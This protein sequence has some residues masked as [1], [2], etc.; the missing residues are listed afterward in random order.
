[1]NR[2]R[3]VDNKFQVIITP[4]IKISPDSSLI[5]GNFE[6]ENLRNFHVLQF[7]TLNDALCEAYNYPDIDWY[8]IVLNHKYIFKRLEDT[9]KQIISDNQLN[10]EF[11]SKLV[12]PLALKNIMFDRVLRGGERFNLRTGL[13]DI[14]SFTIINPWSNNLHNISKMIETY[15]EHVY[16]DDLRIRFKK[17]VDGKI[18]CLYGYT[19]F[20]TIYE[21]KLIPTLLQQWVDWYNKIGYKNEEEAQK[22]YAELMKQQSNLDSGPVYR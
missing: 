12:D 10:V 3:K 20:G 22:S 14:I 17:I 16:R 5:I 7:E 6:D 9:L 21:I 19:E 8:R 11:R 15:T 13:N 2:I 18:I 1:M 4:D